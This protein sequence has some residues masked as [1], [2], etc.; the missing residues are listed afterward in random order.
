MDFMIQRVKQLFQA[1]MAAT[2]A[3][4][5]VVV[6]TTIMMMMMMM[7]IIKKIIIIMIIRTYI[8]SLLYRLT[9]PAPKKTQPDIGY[10]AGST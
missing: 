3:L 9:T 2:N 7:T 8:S 6:T 4:S 1:K 10:E 5:D